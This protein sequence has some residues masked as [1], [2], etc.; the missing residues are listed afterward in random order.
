[1]SIHP[2]IGSFDVE[3]T[4]AGRKT[5]TGISAHSFLTKSSARAFVSAKMFILMPML[6]SYA[7]LKHFSMSYS[8]YVLGHLSRILVIDREKSNS[9]PVEC[10]VIQFRG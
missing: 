4:I 2:L 7:K 8:L 9:S 1:L 10:K 3:V 6:I 5:P